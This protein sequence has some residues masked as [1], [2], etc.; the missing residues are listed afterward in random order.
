MPKKKANIASSPV[1]PQVSSGS[2]SVNSTVRR[3]SFSATSFTD[4]QKKYYRNVKALLKGGLF[5]HGNAR[6]Q[7]VHQA[8]TFLAYGS[9]SGA[10][11]DRSESAAYS[12]D[13]SHYHGLVATQ[14][15]IPITSDEWVATVKQIKNTSY[16]Q[17]YE[18]LLEDCGYSTQ[19]KVGRW[20]VAGDAGIVMLK[21]CSCFILEALQGLLANSD[22]KKQKYALE[23]CFSIVQISSRDALDEAIGAIKAKVVWLLTQYY[24][25][26]VCSP[27]DREQARQV[28][29]II[30]PFPM[31]EVASQSKSD[32][33]KLGGTI[34]RY[35][36]A[37]ARQIKTIKEIRE[38]YDDSWFGLLSD[39]YLAVINAEL[40]ELALT[41]NDHAMRHIID[42]NT[43]FNEQQ[44][45]ERLKF[46]Q[47]IASKID[48]STQKGAIT[49]ENAQ[50]LYGVFIPQ[51][52]TLVDGLLV[53]DKLS[54]KVL[55]E[56]FS[57]FCSS[58]LHLS[59]PDI[60]FKQLGVIDGWRSMGHDIQVAPLIT[61][62]IRILKQNC[63]ALNLSM[64][65]IFRRSFGSNTSEY[66]QWLKLFAKYGS[67]DEIKEWLNS[68]SQPITASEGIAV[69][70]KQREID[71]SN[72]FRVECSQMELV[73]RMG[74]MEYMRKLGDISIVRQRVEAIKSVLSNNPNDDA[75]T[76]VYQYIL[77]NFAFLISIENRE[78]IVLFTPGFVRSLLEKE[79]HIRSMAD[80]NLEILVQLMSFIGNEDTTAIS[81]Q[82]ERLENAQYR[83]RLLQVLA[84]EASQFVPGAGLQGE[85]PYIFQKEEER[86]VAETDV[87][88]AAKEQ[89]ASDA[90]LPNCLSKHEQAIYLKLRATRYS[91]AYSLMFW[92]GDYYTV[93]GLNA[94]LQI[95]KQDHKEGLLPT[96]KN[97]KRAFLTEL[98]KKM[99]QLKSDQ[100]YFAGLRV[101]L[102]DSKSDELL[103]D[104]AKTNILFERS[105]KG[106]KSVF[107][108]AKRVFLVP[109]FLRS[110]QSGSADKLYVK[111]SLINAGICGGF[112]FWWACFKA[113]LF[114]GSSKKS[115][116]TIQ[117]PTRLTSNGNSSF[118]STHAAVIGQ[119]N[120]RTAGTT[121][122]VAKSSDGKIK[123][124]TF[125][126]RPMQW[127]R[128]AA[129]EQADGCRLR[130]Q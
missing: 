91:E 96:E 28:V 101:L 85:F 44:F 129:V 4:D 43:V 113:R 66:T 47:F 6:E 63:K 90:N 75:K 60:L 18:T 32:K 12:F 45:L 114:A 14:Q 2:P 122:S 3:Q 78:N 64:D 35:L 92:S 77:E 58:L 102:Q 54:N 39:S 71:V 95:V 88:G 94:I 49:Q 27:M 1:E 36:L 10:L 89:G 20:V 80:S 52:L 15:I 82:I 117:E 93:E 46:L 55:R 116:L 67:E 62:V 65:D 25:N 106:D 119:L 87:I 108:Q 33:E 61:Q 104:I 107:T 86:A 128:V 72:M 120:A 30:R 13:A 79:D 83:T 127:D 38:S 97:Y 53:H 21:K 37:N 84:G 130:G 111:H 9:V 123:S 68:L 31:S 81:V 115:P 48:I 17:S 23:A 22:I 51:V 103:R 100:D 99:I 26:V 112:G 16:L 29:S 76:N 121:A 57:I 59:E 110:L 69:L 7:Q 56:V 109:D 41:V 124:P 42:D 125:W 74:M 24:L 105:L 8:I 126:G 50:N 118:D 40:A 5:T 34:A 73:A 19:D 98:V 11:N 70:L